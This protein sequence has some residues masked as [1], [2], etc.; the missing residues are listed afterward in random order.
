MASSVEQATRT[1]GEINGNLAE[2]KELSQLGMNGAHSIGMAVSTLNTQPKNCV[3][4]L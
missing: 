1:I 3:R 4:S 2:T